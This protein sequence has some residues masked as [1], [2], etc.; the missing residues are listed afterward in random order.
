MNTH[1]NYSRFARKMHKD[2][3]ENEN[4]EFGWER[5]EI[6]VRKEKRRDK[7]NLETACSNDWCGKRHCSVEL[8][9]VI[10]FKI[11]PP[12]KKYF[13]FVCTANVRREK[14]NLWYSFPCFVSS[15]QWKNSH[16]KSLCLCKRYHFP[17][18]FVW[19]MVFI[20]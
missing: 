15:F 12:A 8:D 16:T 4:I 6:E 13:N 5:V 7:L 2:L 10:L 9:I 11:F 17:D 19:F 3:F 20:G 1:N 18:S 14:G